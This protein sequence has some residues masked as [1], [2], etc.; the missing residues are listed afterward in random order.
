MLET[1]T[2]G[3]PFTVGSCSNCANP[4]LTYLDCDESGTLIHRCLRCDHLVRDE[5]QAIAPERLD[6]YGY[7][8]VTEGGGCGSGGCGSGGCGIRPTS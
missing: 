4:S 7:A 8:V 5:L 6:G 3:S 1:H 2:T